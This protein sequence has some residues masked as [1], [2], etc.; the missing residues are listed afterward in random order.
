VDRQAHNT[1]SKNSSQL[2]LRPS[3][4]FLNPSMMVRF[5]TST[6]PLLLQTFCYT[7]FLLLHRC[8]LVFYS[9]TATPFLKFSGTKLQL[10]VEDY[11]R[12]DTEAAQDLS[13]YEV[14]D[15]NCGDGCKWSGLYPFGEV[16]DGH[17]QKFHLPF[18][19]NKKAR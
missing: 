5:V 12:K 4:L 17:Q 18:S 10:I 11:Y 6:Y 16:I 1:S 7:I 2:P 13:F 19:G 9:L 15:P 3:T 14:Y 8:T